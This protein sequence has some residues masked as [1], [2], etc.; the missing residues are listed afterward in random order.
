MVD[1]LIVIA[2]YIVRRINIAASSTYL[3][4]IALLI[5]PQFYKILDRKQHSTYFIK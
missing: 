4:N 3:S 2:L 5:T 1:F